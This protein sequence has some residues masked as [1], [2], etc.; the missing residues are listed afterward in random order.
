MAQKSS[1]FFNPLGFEARSNLNHKT[2]KL[3]LHST[4]ASKQHLKDESLT[5]GQETALIF[6]FSAEN[7]EVNLNYT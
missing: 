4:R 1:N 5:N 2:S 7:F 3:K 6:W